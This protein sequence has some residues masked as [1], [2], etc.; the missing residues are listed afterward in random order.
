MKQ[1]KNRGQLNKFFFGPDYRNLNSIE[2]RLANHEEK[3]T[4][5]KQLATQIVNEDDIVTLQE[6]IAVM[7]Q[8]K[9]ELEKEVIS[10][11]KGFSLFGWLNKMFI[12]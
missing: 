9:T 7:E 11:S 12:K 8:V 1:V 2:D 4:Q 5:L 3:I 6:Q 10:E